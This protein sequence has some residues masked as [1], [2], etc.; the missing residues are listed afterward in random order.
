MLKIYFAT[1]IIWMIINGCIISIFK[2]GIKEKSK[3]TDEVKKKGILSRLSALFAV[4][5]IPIIRLLFAIGFI[6]LSTC[7]QENYDEIMSK[8]KQ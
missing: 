7:S 1:I 6:Y 2:N 4:S 3:S 8:D 5:A